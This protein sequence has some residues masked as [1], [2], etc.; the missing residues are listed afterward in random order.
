MSLLQVRYRELM[1]GSYGR[2][3]RGQMQKNT[4]ASSET[5]LALVCGRKIIRG[6]PHMGWVGQRVGLGSSWTLTFCMHLWEAKEWQKQAAGGGNNP[7]SCGR[8]CKGILRLEMT[9]L[10]IH[11]KTSRSGDPQR[12]HKIALETKNK[13]E[14]LAR[15]TEHEVIFHQCLSK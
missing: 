3:L 15:V 1:L 6:L 5:C 8:N 2:K 9:P 11:Q 14:T 4:G 12:H 7:R 10:E 13:L